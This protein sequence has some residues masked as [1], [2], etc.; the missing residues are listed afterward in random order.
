MLLVAPSQMALPNKTV[1][2]ETLKNTLTRKDVKV[3]ALI[4]N[5]ITKI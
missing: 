1:C 4:L 3:Q 2:S 5:Q